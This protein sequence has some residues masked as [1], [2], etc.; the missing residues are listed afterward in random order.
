MISMHKYEMKEKVY[1]IFSDNL[2]LLL[3]LI[4]V[5][6]TL[7][8][9]VSQSFWLTVIDWLIWFVFLLEFVLKVVVEDTLTTYIKYNKLNSAISL[10][11]VVSPV[12]A[13]VTENLVPFPVIGLARALRIFRIFG[14]GDSVYTKHRKVLKGDPDVKKFNSDQRLEP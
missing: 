6:V 5:P 8:E 11:I 2:M 13:I 7:Y 10:I 4:A 14:Y 1:A 12:L 3:A 9:L